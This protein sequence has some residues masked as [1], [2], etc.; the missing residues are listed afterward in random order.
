MRCASMIEP[1]SVNSTA[2][3]EVEFDSILGVGIKFYF[4]FVTL[5]KVCLL[6]QYTWFFFINNDP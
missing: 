4:V 6:L 2:Y 1:T 5:L 3:R